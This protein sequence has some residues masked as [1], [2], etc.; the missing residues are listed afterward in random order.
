MKKTFAVLLLLILS[1][2]VFAADDITFSGG[3]SSVILKEGQRMVSLTQGAAVQTGSLRI[4][5]DSILIE[6][7]DYEDITCEGNITV[8][9]A[10]KGLTIQTSR[11]YYDRA[12]QT[13]LIPAYSEIN[14]TENELAASSSA[15]FYDIDEEII[16]LSM[17]VSLA[18]ETSSGLLTASCQNAVYN[19]TEETLILSSQTSVSWKDDSYTAELVTIDLESESISLDGQIGGTIHG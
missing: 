3:T 2:C 6:G 8:T 11:I 17:N 16:E 15:L 4:A 13:I 18:K 19:R 1:L 10:E 14:D 9:D 5:A 12:A 7:E